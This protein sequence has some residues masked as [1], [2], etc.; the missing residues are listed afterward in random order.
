MVKCIDLLNFFVFLWRKFYL[1][2]DI[3]LFTS[4]KMHYV[5]YDV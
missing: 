1:L 4:D 2:K 5:F 3:V